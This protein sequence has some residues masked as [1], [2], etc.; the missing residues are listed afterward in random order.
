MDA[1]KTVMLSPA[2]LVMVDLVN[3]ANTAALRD[4]VW[5]AREVSDVIDITDVDGPVDMI[6]DRLRF[7]ME[8]AKLTRWL[9]SEQ[10]RRIQTPKVKQ[11]LQRHS[12][13]S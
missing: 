9:W 8:E 5:A 4:L 1:D 7:G 13:V 12:T 2:K 3:A 11:C 10:G 6:M